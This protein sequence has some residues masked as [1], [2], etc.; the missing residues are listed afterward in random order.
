MTSRVLWIGGGIVALLFALL[1]VGMFRDPYESEQEKQKTERAAIETL[2]RGVEGLQ[3]PSFQLATLDGKAISL[4]DFRGQPMVI[5]FWATWCR[6]CE[7]EHPNLVRAAKR[8]ESQGVA[9]L[10][11]LY[12][13]GAERARQM[14]KRLGEAYPTVVDVGGKVSAEYGV[15]G[16]PETYFINANGVIVEKVAL[17]FLEQSD[18]DS[19]IVKV[20]Q[21]SAQADEMSQLDESLLGEPE[22]E[23]IDVDSVIYTRAQ[24]LG[25]GLRCPVCRSQAVSESG[26]GAARIMMRQI[27]D[28]VG[29][30]YSNHQIVTYF[31]DQYG[32]EIRL[33]PPKSGLGL[34]AWLSPLFALLVG[35]FVFRSM[36]RSETQKTVAEDQGEDV[37]TAALLSELEEKE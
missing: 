23:P 7:E 4:S 22:G 33:S 11:V 14:L 15:T 29:M 13:D 8:F 30:G 21:S 9:F 31:V 1:S 5:N 28:L 26:S 34:I 20:M 37:F 19:R 24:K 25:K 27:E 3:A 17:P 35:L 2:Q 6:P 16:V 18:L 32:D 12:D 10:G 36:T